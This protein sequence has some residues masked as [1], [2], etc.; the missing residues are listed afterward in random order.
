MFP[1]FVTWYSGILTH[2]IPSGGAKWAMEAPHV[3]QAAPK[4]GAIVPSTGLAGA[5]RDMLTDIVQP[6]WAIPLL[7]LAKLQFRDIMGYALLFLVVYARV[8]T[9]G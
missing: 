7:G 5:W 9:A 2:L 1:L 4:M 8:A 3:L 6:F